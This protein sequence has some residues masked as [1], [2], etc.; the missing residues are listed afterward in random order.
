MDQN[1]S[2]RMKSLLEMLE[3]EPNDS[4]LNYALALEFHKQGDLQKAT[5]LIQNV[6]SNDENYL[7][8]YLQLGQL[9]EESGFPAKA[10]Q[11]YENGCAIAKQQNN[12]KTLGELNEAIT[13]LED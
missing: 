4:F 9:Y 6:L 10:L 3:K 7:G 12:R 11:V 13:L 8:A 5:L 1:A 2:N